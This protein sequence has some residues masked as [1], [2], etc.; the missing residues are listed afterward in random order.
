M[1]ALLKNARSTGFAS[2]FLEKYQCENRKL[3]IIQEHGLTFCDIGKIEIKPPMLKLW[4]IKLRGSQSFPRQCLI[5]LK[6]ISS[7]PELL[8]VFR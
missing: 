3:L 2:R 8:F 1:T 7:A 5:T 4:T 6:F